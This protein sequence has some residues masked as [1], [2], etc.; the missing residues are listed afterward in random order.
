M[1]YDQIIKEIQN[2]IYKPVYFLMGEEPYYIDKITNLIQNSVLEESE[3]DFN[4]TI[5]YGKDSNILDIISA[6]KRF[7]MM[8]NHQVIIVKEAQELKK[9]D[10]A[11]LPYL[12]APLKSTIL[13]FN[14]KYKS[15]N[16]VQKLY[17]ALNNNSFVYESEKI[18]D[19][20]LAEWIEQYLKTHSLNITAKGSSMLADYLGNDLTKITNE[21]EKLT[22]SLPQNAM[23]TP[24]II[25]SNIGISKD[26]N[27]FELSNAI[28]K[29]EHGKANQIIAYFA[30]NDKKFPLVSL[31]PSLYMFFA[32][33]LKFHALRGKQKNEIAA[34]IGMPPFLVD[35]LGRMAANYP[36]NKAT[37]V[38][39]LL[40]E[41]DLKSKGV[42]NS[43]TND[44]ELLKEL[45]FKIM[46]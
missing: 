14:Y 8:A 11:L 9:I 36:F 37:N 23:I 38:I 39:S 45:V 19:Y 43:S 7:P 35:E 5:L 44:G 41:Y 42:E 25:E 17:K 26:F 21:I 12:T 4:Q 1:N 20:K 27:A 46:H 34:A 32:K 29:K 10:E 6:A 16:K 30:K 2:K 13:V 18:K 33:I 15:L 31:I 28:G 40:R 3:R 22:I 24:E